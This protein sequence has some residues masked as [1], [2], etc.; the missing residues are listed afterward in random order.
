MEFPGHTGDD[1]PAAT[2]RRGSHLRVDGGNRILRDRRRH[3]LLR[4]ADLVQFPKLATAWQVYALPSERCGAPGSGSD[5]ILFDP[6]RYCRDARTATHGGQHSHLVLDGSECVS[7]DH[8]GE[9]QPIEG[10]P[11]V[12]ANGSLTNIVV[13]RAGTA[14]LDS[15]KFYSIC[16]A[17]GQRARLELVLRGFG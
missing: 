14:S 8:A 10:R 5:L 11:I 12:L 3:V 9:R 1:H 4:N 6:G 13:R 17:A 15:K 16:R 7:S 2:G